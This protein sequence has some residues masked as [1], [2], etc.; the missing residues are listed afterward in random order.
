MT[1][2]AP[3]RASNRAVAFPMPDAPPVISATLF[4][5][6]MRAECPSIQSSARQASRDLGS[7]AGVDVSRDVSRIV[8]SQERK[9][10]GDLLR[11]GMTPQRHLTVDLFQHF[12]GILCTLHR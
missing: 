9:Q 1:M 6:S 8:G 2:L 5:K 12:V 10:G 7:I 11:L 4:C 3:S